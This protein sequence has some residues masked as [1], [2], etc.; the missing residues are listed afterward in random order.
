VNFEHK[1]AQPFSAARLIELREQQQPVFVNMTAAWCIT[2]LVNERSTLA[3]DSIQQLFAEKNITY[4]VGDWTNRDPAI[5]EFL[6]KYDR[7]GVPIYVYFNSCGK[8]EILPQILTNEIV[9]NALKSSEESC[10]R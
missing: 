2:C 3:Q 7:V 9:Q 6:A 5:T 10:P 8:Y 4:L 1:N